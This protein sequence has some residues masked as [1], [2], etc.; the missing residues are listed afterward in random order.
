[1]KNC[2]I[3]IEQ[4]NGKYQRTT[5]YQLDDYRVAQAI[6]NIL[7][8]VA[9]VDRG[10]IPQLNFIHRD[11]FDNNEALELLDQVISEE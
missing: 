2:T 9:E 7:D 1:M 3:A 8:N 11:S 4:R 6:C 10:N 5:L